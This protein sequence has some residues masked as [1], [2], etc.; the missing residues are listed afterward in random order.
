MAKQL[1]PLRY[2]P[3]DVRLYLIASNWDIIASEQAFMKRCGQCKDEIGSLL[4]CARI[5][6]RL[7]CLCFLYEKR[8]AP[9]SKWFGTAF[10]QLD[11]AAPLK[12]LLTTALHSQTL[13]LREDA[14]VKAQAF[15]ADKF[16]EAVSQKLTGTSLAQLPLIGIFSQ[17]GGLSAVSDD[18]RY[19]Q[20]IRNFFLKHYRINIS[21]V[22]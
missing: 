15:V 3:N 4:I 6:E 21:A 11:I 17:P 18:S 19:Q 2:Y 16:A 10:G 5:A 7:M 13:E 8:Y 12:T 22:V 20:N 1:A 14:L 9:Y